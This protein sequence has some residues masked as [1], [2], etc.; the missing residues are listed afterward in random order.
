M[1]RLRHFIACLFWSGIFVGFLMILDH[2]THTT[3]SSDF[4]VSVAIAYFT[5]SGP[6]SAKIER[7]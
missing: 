4:Y 2:L 5:G 1:P 3:R 6:F 7:N